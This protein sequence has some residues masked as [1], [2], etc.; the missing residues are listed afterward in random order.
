MVICNKPTPTTQRI[1]SALVSAISRFNSDFTNSIF[2]SV[3]FILASKSLLVMT[4][5]SRQVGW[6]EQRETHRQLISMG[7]GYRLYPSYFNMKL[8][9]FI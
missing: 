1:N 5:S 7:F 3:S 4:F 9:A 8:L 6:V 2:N